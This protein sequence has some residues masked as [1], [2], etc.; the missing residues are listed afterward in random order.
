MVEFFIGYVNFTTKGGPLTRKSR[1]TSF[2]IWV[3]VIS[4]P[5]FSSSEHGFCRFNLYWPLYYINVITTNFSSTERF[6]PTFPTWGRHRGK[7]FEPYTFNLISVSSKRIDFLGFEKH[8]LSPAL[9]RG[10]YARLG[11][12]GERQF[13][14]MIC[15]CINLYRRPLGFIIS[16][17]LLLISTLPSPMVTPSLQG[18]HREKAAQRPHTGN[19]QPSARPFLYILYILLSLPYRPTACPV[20]Q[21][22]RLRWLRRQRG[23]YT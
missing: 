1:W 22:S 17:L 9:D 19:C 5:L 8:W 2:V 13:V 10:E 21:K 16:T 3:C 4:Q 7:A 14:E 11:R 18:R 12:G 20:L 23:P 15:F 6:A